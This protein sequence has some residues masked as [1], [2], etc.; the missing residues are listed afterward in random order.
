MQQDIGEL[1]TQT[2]PLSRLATVTENAVPHSLQRVPKSAGIRVG[3]GSV[4]GNPEGHQF[5]HLP[6]WLTSYGNGECGA[7]FLAKGPQKCWDSG[8][9]WQRGRESGGAPVQTPPDLADL[10]EFGGASGIGRGKPSDPSKSSYGNGESVDGFRKREPV[11]GGIQPKVDTVGGNSAQDCDSPPETT[12]IH[13]KDWNPAQSNQH[14]A[15]VCLTQN[16]P[17]HSPLAILPWNLDPDSVKRVPK[18]V[19]FCLHLT[20]WEGILVDVLN[21]RSQMSLVSGILVADVIQPLKPPEFC[22]RTGIL[23][24]PQVRHRTKESNQLL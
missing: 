8:G 19:E 18:P 22:L 6:I 7:A 9:H 15:I 3:T 13:P 16:N 24:A 1:A 17:K 10:V 21:T 2:S 4:G 23:V 14:T 11:H 20:P 12:G 5:K